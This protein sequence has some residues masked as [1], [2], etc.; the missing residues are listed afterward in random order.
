MYCFWQDLP[1]DIIIYDLVILTLKFDLLFVLP[2]KIA[3]IGIRAGT[4]QDVHG[5]VSILIPSIRFFSNRFY[6]VCNTMK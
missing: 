5:S 4:V 6:D 1:H 2:A 3:H